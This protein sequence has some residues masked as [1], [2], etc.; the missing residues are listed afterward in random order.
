MTI[1]LS[2]NKAVLIVLTA[3][4]FAGC[5]TRPTLK[6]AY[7]NDFLI[8]V[9]VNQKQFDNE[10]QRGVSIIKAQFNSISPENALKW[11]SVHPEPGEYDFTNADRY[12]AFGETNHMVIIGH[13]LVWNHQTPRSVFEDTNGNHVTCEVLLERM[14]DHIQTVVGRYKGRIK[15][16]DVVNEALKDDGTLRPSR[17][18]KIIGPDYIEKAF[19]YA[20]EADPDAELYYNDFSLENEAK[21]K[22]AIELIKK[23]KADGIPI[24]AVG[25]QDHLKMG[26]P[27]V[28]QEDATISD[29]A[30][31][32]VKVMITELDVDVVRATQ[33]NRTADINANAQ[34]VT[35]ANIYSNGLPA[36]VQQALAKRYADIFAVYLKHRDV[37]ERVTFWGVTDGDSW[38]NTP[39]RMNYPLLFDRNG[40]PKPA[41]TAVTQATRK[42][43]PE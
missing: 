43:V 36:D 1:H 13:T 24:T 35:G 29:F 5:A 26:W 9:A 12:V 7:K 40:R 15:D 31:L 21:R 8:G 2:L 22:G 41:F 4:V 14:H 23:L 20:H 19:Q 3:G 30:K 25:L 18:E 39:G 32:G 42:P 10:D 6:E 16:W 34:L 33:G 27:T 37:I 17:W 38:L 11:A 28:E